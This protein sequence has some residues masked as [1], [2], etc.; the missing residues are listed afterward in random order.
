MTKATHALLLC[1]AVPLGLGGCSV[2][3]VVGSNSEPP[4]AIQ[5]LRVD[6]ASGVGFLPLQ[7]TI[8]EPT[9]IEALA[10]SRIAIKPAANEI[11]YFSAAAWTDKLPRLLKLRLIESFEKSRVVK[12]VSSGEDRLR[13]DVAIAWEV[14]NFQIEVN[15]SAAQAHV[16]VY[17]KLID[18]GYGRQIAAQAFSVVAPARDDSVEAG[19]EALQSAFSATSVK[20][21]RW[22]AARKI[23]VVDAGTPAGTQ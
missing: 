16:E 15:G 20:I 5:D 8:Y 6:G 14:R 13:G 21:M 12:A 3:S 4:P 23:V 2:A 1:L 7:V 9:A 11:N 18:E 22:L 17:V 19:V 10:G